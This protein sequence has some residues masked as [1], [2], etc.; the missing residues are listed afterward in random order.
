M[1]AIWKWTKVTLMGLLIL[2][3]AL[4][5]LTWIAG[6]WAKSQLA[7]AHPAP[8]RLVDVGGYD[9][10]L[11]CLGEGSP[12]V[13][14][15]AGLNDFSLQWSSV[16]TEISQFTRVCVYDRAGFGWSEPSP[17]ARTVATMVTELHTLLTNAGINGP[18]VLAG[19][20]F[21]GIV[22][23]EF[24]RQHPEAVA[25]LVLVD[26]AHEQHFERVPAFAALTEATVQQ[27][28]QLA[29]LSGLGLMALSPEQI[30]ARGLEG[31]ALEAYR[32]RLATTD[33]FNAAA[34]ESQAFLAEFGTAPDEIAGLGNLPLIV[35]TR[36]RPDPLPN[37]SAQENAGY[38][39][40]WQQMQIELA[41]LSSNSTQRIA[42][43]SGHYIQLDEPELVIETV[44]QLVEATGST[45]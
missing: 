41:G 24:A 9:L 13:V 35:L 38:E 1:T 25:G 23:R 26:S 6:A 36:G 31:E 5:G 12:T 7:Q 33:Y 4:G 16:Q 21:G 34:N 32:A 45:N 30:P 17:Q 43:H 3:V 2:A 29:T 28:R 19:H 44:R 8:G 40:T 42:E 18:L 14:V 15:E 39:E 20:S 22:V 27:F 37:L 11:H 10:H